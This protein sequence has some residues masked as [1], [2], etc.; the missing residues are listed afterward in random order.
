MLDLAC[1]CAMIYWAVRLATSTTFTI[2]R[3]TMS[4]SLPLDDYP[5]VHAEFKLGGFCVQHGS[6]N[7]LVWIVV[8]QASKETVKEDT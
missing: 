8:D 7:T 6:A 2:S 1:I 5:N 4:M 3:T